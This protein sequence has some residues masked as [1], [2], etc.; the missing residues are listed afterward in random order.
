MSQTESNEANALQRTG[1]ET[2]DPTTA[3]APTQGTAL[4]QFRTQEH[5]L[6]EISRSSRPAIVT[7]LVIIGLFF[8]SIV[9]WMIYL[10]LRSEIH[11]P[12]EI[13][14]KTKRQTVQHLEGGIVKEILVKDGDQVKAGQPL[15]RL[16]SDQVQ[17]LVNVME[18]QDL[19]ETAYMARLEAESK[20]LGSIP[21]P[22]SITARAGTPAVARTIQAEN[23]LFAARRVAFQSQVQLFKLQIAEIRASSRGTQE[24]LATK[25][26]E[27]ASVREQLEANQTLQKQGYVTNTVVLELQRTLAAHTGEREMIAAQLAS[28]KQRIM[29]LEQRILAL[30]ADRVQGAITEMKQAALRR[31]DQQE[32]VRPLRDTL[33]RQVIRAPIAG[34]IVG[35]K[36]TTIGGVIMPR[37]TLMEIAP[38]GD[39][40]VLDAK[41]RQEDIAEVKVG[42][43]ADIMINGV[44]LNVRPDVKAKVVYVSDDR[45]VSP[46]AQGGQPYYEAQ[47]EFDQTTLKTLG[48]IQLKAGMSALANIATKP[49]TPITDILDSAHERMNKALSTR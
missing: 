38:I 31:I 28:D 35:L 4:V 45:L 9:L 19:A 2:G 33:E 20:D 18:E 30:R 40:L 5:Y 32:K 8:G 41:I 22:R 12:A 36:V 48:E 23:R 24:R 13:V 3:L 21:F 7:G 39:H 43:T 17:P 47:L 15:I 14:F 25:K 37:D 11:V 44:H 27:I 42:Q 29:E 1:K 16:V 26:Q 6:Q 34:K 46:A 10:P 49:R